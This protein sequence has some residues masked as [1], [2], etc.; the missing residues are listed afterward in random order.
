MQELV[1]SADEVSQIAIHQ[2]KELMK[3]EHM[4]TEAETTGAHF[5]GIIQSHKSDTTKIEQ[6]HASVKAASIGKLHQVRVIKMQVQYVAWCTFCDQLG[7]TGQDLPT[8]GCL[9]SHNN[10]QL[11]LAGVARTGPSPSP[12]ISTHELRIASYIPGFGWHPFGVLQ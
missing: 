10:T 9:T 7:F 11:H 3:R 4:L 2:H 12:T 5:K 1:A 6:L 8:R